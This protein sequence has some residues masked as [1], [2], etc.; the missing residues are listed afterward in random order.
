MAESKHRTVIGREVS[1]AICVLWEQKGPFQTRVPVHFNGVNGFSNLHINGILIKV[2]LHQ[3][4]PDC[5]PAQALKAQVEEKMV[6]DTLI[7]GG[8]IALV[9]T[10][11]VHT[12]E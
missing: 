8:L 4:N 1:S 10:V 5:R 6:R 2:L 12:R 11:L 7:G 9:I 3:V